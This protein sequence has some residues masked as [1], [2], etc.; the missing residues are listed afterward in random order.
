MNLI[1][2]IKITPLLDTLRLQKISDAEYFSTEY[3]DYI[4]NSR[5]GFIDPNNGGS[6]EKFLAG[7]KGN[8]IFSD[9][10]SLGTI[11]HE[12][13]L[14]PE[15]FSLCPD[16]SRPSAKVGFIADELAS[17]RKGGK[18][19]DFTKDEFLEACNIVDYYKGNPKESKIHEIL[20]SIKEYLSK[21]EEFLKSNPNVST[22]LDSK[23]LDKAKG[24]I[25]ALKNNKKVQ[26]LLHPTGL[27]EDPISECEQAIL[28]DAVVK[29]PDLP[30]FTIRLKS[31]LDNYTID[32]ENNVITVNDVKTIGRT[33]NNSDE[34]ILKYHY[35]RE[36]TMYCFLLSL[37]AKQFYGFPKKFKVCSNF[38]W[39][40]TV[41]PTGNYTTYATKVTPMTPELFKLGNNEFKELLRRAA[42]TL[43]FKD[44]IQVEEYFQSL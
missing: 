41:P 2:D 19:A 21:L 24:C 30:E 42:V 23:N 5:L 1:E 11:V 29:C 22:Y 25:S 35:Y 33:L 20:P 39:V 12:Q 10:L 4:S 8:R 9:S 28:L 7:F 44:A 27:L 17:M 18:L 16:L 37:C 38:L 3:S 31:K 40:S 6:P 15:L 43:Y 36:M 32:K 13:T 34:Q 26:N 14:Q